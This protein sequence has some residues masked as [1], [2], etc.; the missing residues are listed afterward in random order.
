MDNFWVIVIAG[1]LE[2]ICAVKIARKFNDA[3]PPWQFFV[4]VFN[5]IAYGKFSL[6]S[7][8]YLFTLAFIQG[9][10]LLLSFTHNVSPHIAFLQA[11]ISLA[12]FLMWGVM[13]AR[14]AVRL[15]QGFWSYFTATVFS[16]VAGNFAVTALLYM[17]IPSF[18]GDMTAIP[19]WA[20]AVAT[21]IVFLPF[22][23]LAFDKNA[24]SSS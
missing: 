16:M 17:F 14:I 21:V 9:I 20:E 24:R 5:V 6:S 19:L 12:S 2:G 7:R 18:S 10:D 11:V 3:T 15:G 8:P 13:V 22:L 23:S 1:I 4:P